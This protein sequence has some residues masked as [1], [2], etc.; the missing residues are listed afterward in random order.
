[1]TGLSVKIKFWVFNNVPVYRLIA[2]EGEP[3][4]GGTEGAPTEGRKML[5]I[6]KL[7]NARA[8]YGLFKMR[9]YVLN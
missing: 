5:K 7:K 6:Y 8:R 9:K 1:M 4:S 3:R 2:G